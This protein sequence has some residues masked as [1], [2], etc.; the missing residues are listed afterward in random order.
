M[1]RI[2]DLDP[3]RSRREYAEQIE[4]DLHWLGLDWDEGGL[5]DKG[6]CAPYTQS[7][8]SEIYTAILERLRLTGYTYPCHCTRADIMSTQ[9]PHRSDNRVIYAGTCRPKHLPSVSSLPSTPHSVRL[10]ILSEEISFTDRLY[11]PQKIDPASECGDIVLRRADGS[12]AY[13]LAVVAD[14]A[15]MGITEVVR[16]SDLL[17]SAATQ[18][19]LYRLLGWTPPEFAHV[20][21]IC[22][23]SGRR[24][25]KRDQSLA[26]DSLRSLYHPEEILGYLGYLA[27]LQPE[28]QPLAA[29]QLL[30]LFDWKKLPKADTIV[31]PDEHP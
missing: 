12:W 11:G 3:Q 24:L 6:D 28:P 10:F 21:L 25:S 18:I 26:M 19:Y 14:D 22:N 5:A 2:E 31:L 9:A 1:L 7:R 8:R 23:S 17:N 15:M 27:R 4:D 20:P 13:Q 30:P 16:G 29:R